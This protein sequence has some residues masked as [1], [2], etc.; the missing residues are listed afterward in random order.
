MR[1]GMPRVWVYLTMV[2]LVLLAVAIPGP[3]LSAPRSS[4]GLPADARAAEGEETIDWIDTRGPGNGSAYAL[5]L[6]YEHACLY[7]GTDRGVWKYD[8]SSWLGTGGD[9]AGF[10]VASLAYDPV[11]DLLYAGTFDHGVWKYDGSS[12]Q[13]LG[14]ET[15]G[16]LITSLAYDPEGGLLYAGTL[17]GVYSYDGTVWEDTGG[18]IS[19]RFVESLSFDPVRGLLYV[20]TMS[21]VYQYDGS[22]WEATGSEPWDT[23][24]FP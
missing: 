5:A 15:T 10:K 16:P 24:R 4:P 6:D 11:N 3:V 12:W 7:R 9:V 2:L 22:N 23:R 17:S 13:G 8:G 20:G 14:M 1:K 21:G 18:E 19:G